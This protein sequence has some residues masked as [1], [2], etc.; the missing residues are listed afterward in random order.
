MLDTVVRNGL[1]S[2]QSGPLDLDIGIQ[3]GRIVQ[4]K[5]SDTQ[6]PLEGVRTIDAAGKTVVPGGVDP[7]VHTSSPMPTLGDGIS[8]Y[9][10]DR[11]SM[12]AAFGGTTTMLDFAHWRPGDDL[13]ET[14][15]RKHA[16]WRN[17]S[18]VDYGFHGTF[19]EPE[20]PFDILDQVEDAVADGHASFK[21]WM[22]NTT[23]DRKW[24]KTDI[25]HIWGLMERTAAA[26]GMLCVHAEDDDIVMYAYKRLQHEGRTALRHMS[27]AHNQLSE[28]LSFQ[29]V[30]SLAG[31]VG[32]PLYIMHV[33]AQVGIEAIR[34]ARGTGQPVYGE[35]L[36]HYANYS[37]EVYAQ[38]N[39][40]IYHTYPSLKA[41]TDRDSMW[42]AL[43]AGTLSTIATDSVCVDLDVKTTGKTILDAVGGHVGVEVRMAVAYT[44][45]VTKRGLPLERFVDLTSRNAARVMGAYPQKGEIA[46]GSDADLVLLDTSAPHIITATEL[47]EAD[48]TPWE[49]YVASAWPVLTMVRGEVLVENGRLTGAPPSGRLLK[50]SISSSV[51][52]RPAL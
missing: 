8:S 29:R 20:I 44:E 32:A 35:C 7:H 49:G 17:R 9:G 11:V 13:A 43:A 52:S 31:H 23:P 19:R 4:L 36:P 6:S 47:H 48:Y 25:G 12:A 33:S 5:K 22:T 27:E 34:A 50:R 26:N 24:Q 45:A 21:V 30:I 3:D 38:S 14:F 28:Q 51:L 46:I 42:G 2:T 39:G 37:D 18:Y 15:E 1:V 41:S 16:D 10:P 40:A